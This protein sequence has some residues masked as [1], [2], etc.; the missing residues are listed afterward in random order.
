MQRY[1]RKQRE[2][3]IGTWSGDKEE[4]VRME[5]DLRREVF[6]CEDVPFAMTA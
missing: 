4:D 1:A 6:L 3:E 5:T 2:I